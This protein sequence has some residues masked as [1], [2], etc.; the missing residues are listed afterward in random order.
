MSNSMDMQEVIQ[1][2]GIILYTD[3]LPVLAVL[4]G[5]ASRYLMMCWRGQVPLCSLLHG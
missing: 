2:Q 4:L 5:A 3:C 1:D